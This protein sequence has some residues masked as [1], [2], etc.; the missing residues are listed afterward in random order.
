MASSPPSPGISTTMMRSRSSSLSKS[1]TYDLTPVKL[2]IAG[3]VAGSTAKTVVAPL[4]RVRIMAQ[5][6]HAHRTSL[7]TGTFMYTSCIF[8]CSA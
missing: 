4:E 6:G 1:K 3:G 7:A 2:V 8:S 5:T